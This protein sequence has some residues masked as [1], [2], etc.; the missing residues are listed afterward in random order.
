[1]I[2]LQEALVEEWFETMKHFK[3]ELKEFDVVVDGNIGLIWGFYVE[4]FQK[5]GEKPERILVR[6]SEARRRAEGGLGNTDKP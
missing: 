3:V 5:V 2:F 1:M 4:D 6:F